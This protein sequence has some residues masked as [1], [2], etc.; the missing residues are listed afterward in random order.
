MWDRSVLWV[1][2]EKEEEGKEEEEEENSM[3]SKSTSTLIHTGL[4]NG[5]WK[6]AK[7][8]QSA[9]VSSLVFSLP[10]TSF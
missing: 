1:W 10:N 3:S 4:L 5:L 9:N 2:E 6:T 7:I 8:W